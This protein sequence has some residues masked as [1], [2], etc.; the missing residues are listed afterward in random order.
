MLILQHA[1][2]LFEASGIQVRPIAHHIYK[3]K[4]GV[5]G[6]TTHMEVEVT[7]PAYTIFAGTDEEQ[8]IRIVIPNS[9]NGTL[10]LEFILM[11]F[12]LLCSNGSRGWVRD[13]SIKIKHRQ[14]ADQKMVDALNLYMG[15]GITTAIEKIEELQTKVAD[16]DRLISYLQNNKVLSGQ[17][18]AE[19][20][21]GAWLIANEPTSFWNVYNIFTAQITHVWGRNFSSKITKYNVLNK[22]VVHEWDRLLSPERVII[23]IN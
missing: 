2:E 10:C 21:M 16:T 3:G 23:P 6:R 5:L 20:L 7:N 13:F 14:G 19:K 1:L 8:R 22:E 4:D 18:W 15:R 12:K 11:L 17:R 9:F